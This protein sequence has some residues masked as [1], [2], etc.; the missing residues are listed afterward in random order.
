MVRCLISNQRTKV[1][2]LLLAPAEVAQLEERLFCNQKVISS[3]LILGSNIEIVQ[4]VER[5]CYI[6]QVIG[7]S[8]I[9]DTYIEVA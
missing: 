5:L 6:Q 8:P 4:L 1:R 7:S 9:F 2:F 3:I